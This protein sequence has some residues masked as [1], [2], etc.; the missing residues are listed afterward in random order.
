MS[1]ISYNVEPSV[2]KLP[3]KVPYNDYVLYIPSHNFEKN[4]K[5][6]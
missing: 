6:T 2:K 4:L 5:P 3:K 1:P